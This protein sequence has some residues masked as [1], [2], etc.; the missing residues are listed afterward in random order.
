MAGKMVLWQSFIHTLKINRRSLS[1]RF[2]NRLRQ[3]SLRKY[4]G[5]CVGTFSPIYGP[6]FR[7]CDKIINCCENSF[8]Y[9]LLIIHN[10]FLYTFY[11]F[12]K[13]KGNIWLC[14]QKCKHFKGKNTAFL[15]VFCSKWILLHQNITKM[16]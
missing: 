4:K 11:N 9:H 5:V 8:N 10:F 13:M 15:D 3:I 1:I 2:L 16:F 6:N 14:Q 7:F 12:I